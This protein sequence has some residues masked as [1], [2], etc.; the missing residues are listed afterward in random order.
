MSATLLLH[1]FSLVA[2]AP[3]GIGRIRELVHYLAFAGGLSERRDSDSTAEEVVQD[4]LQKKDEYFA[5]WSTRRGSRKHAALIDV[6]RIHPSH[7]EVTD[8]GNLLDL[9]NG[10]AFKSTEW[11]TSGK[12]IVRIQNLND[13]NAPFNYFQGESEERY[14]VQDGDMLLSWS[15]TPGTSFGAFIWDRGDAVLNQHIF[16][17]AIFSKLLDKRY[18]QLAINA[19][20]DV[21]I[22]SARGGVGLKHVTKGQ[23]E[24]MRIPLPPLEEQKRIVAKVD[25]L[26]GLCDRLESQLA[27][28][29]KI[30]PLLS[31]AN[32]GR[33]VKEP[34]EENLQAIFHESPI[35]SVEDM[36]H[37]VLSM[38]VRGKLTS[39]N[40]RA[41]SA[42]DDFPLLVDCQTKN[43]KSQ[44]PSNWLQVALGDLGEWRGG[45]TPSKSRPEYWEGDIPW[46]SPKDMKV[47]TIN[48]TQDMVSEEAISNSSTR[49][50]PTGSILIVIRGMILIHTFP[51]AIAGRELTINQDMKSILPLYPATA[52]YLYVALRAF[53]QDVLTIVQRSSH[54]T[55]KLLTR[56]IQSFVV[57]I[58]PLVE[59]KQIVRRVNELMRTLDKLQESLDSLQAIGGHVAETIIASITKTES[60]GINLMS[61]PKIEVVTRLLPVG[62]PKQG[63]HAPL[64]SILEANDNGM[65]AKSLWSSSGLEID[66]FYRQLK[67]EMSNGWIVEPEPATVKEVELD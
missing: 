67:T 53:E 14:Q 36:R 30:L 65:D 19:C 31:Q 32:H 17:V 49:L 48:E 35:Y 29:A 9:I 61:T 56:D 60:E 16:K 7:W 62:K 22:G 26:M 28:R 20:L 10:R 64:R 47:A 38:A 40:D 52:E 46:V 33:F 57:P 15:G 63:T 18:L 12:P 1:E 5:N 59:Q 51:V 24:A 50:I 25:E 4:A 58:P 39:S 66:A 11:N 21:L 44:F 6:A 43:P 37:T 34:A 55:C 3:N 2:R 8:A 27:E 42:V 23:I 54:G 45:G 13:P 41:Q